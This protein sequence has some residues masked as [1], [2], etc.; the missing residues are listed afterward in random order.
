V[1]YHNQKYFLLFMGHGIAGLAY[2]LLWV[3]VRAFQ[4]FGG[5]KLPNGLPNV[6]PGAVIT[7]AVDG[8]LSIA[9]MLA[10]AMLFSYQ[11]WLVLRNSTTIEHYDYSRRKRWAK[12]KQVKFIYP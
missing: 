5:E 2:V 3:I 11:M 7:M 9:L 1:G 12:R 6:A 10:I 4:I 8:I